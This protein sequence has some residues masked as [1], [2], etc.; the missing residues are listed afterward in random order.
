VFRPLFAVLPVLLAAACAGVPPVEH[1]IA[2]GWAQ[3]SVNAVIF[4]RNAVVSH[5]DQQYAAF[6]D[7]E[8]R[9]VLARRTLGSPDW[10]LARTPYRGRVRDAHNSISIAVD[11][12]GVLH[13]AWDHHGNALRYARGVAPGAL[14]LGPEQPMLGR[15]EDRVTYPEFYLLPGGDLLFL[16]RDGASGNGDLMMNRWDAARGVW[17]RVQSGLL[18][19]EGQRNAYWQFALDPQ[20]GFHLSWVWRET[21]DVAT[22]HDLGYA[23]STDGGASWTRSDGTAYALPITAASAEYAC[24]IPQGSE[25]INQTS[26]AADA[27]GRPVIAGYWRPAGAAAPQYM[28]VRHDGAGWQAQAVGRRKS[29]FTLSGG[30]SKRLPISRPQV[31]TRIRGGRTEAVLLFRDRERGDRVSAAVCADLDAGGWRFVDLTARPVGQWEPNFD[32]VRWQ[33]DGAL[34]LLVQRVGQG[35]G[36]RTEDLPPQPVSLL[37]W[38][39]GEPGASSR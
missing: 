5:G 4:R 27:S 9:V 29:D 21:G 38:R 14:E 20:G 32:P 7:P 6:Y 37:E 35:D 17:R 2:D 1:P 12:A 33:E 24:R 11:G 19:G 30:G 28:L 39:P 18:D 26:M 25:L 34:H 10:E 8:A 15:E 36:E 16:Y 31:A 3:T 23:R 13:V 22:N